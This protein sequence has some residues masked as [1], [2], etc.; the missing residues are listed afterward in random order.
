MEFVIISLAEM[1]RI[2]FPKMEFNKVK[3]VVGYWYL[4]NGNIP[5]AKCENGKLSWIEY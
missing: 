2:S 1:I 5:H 3:D 4:K